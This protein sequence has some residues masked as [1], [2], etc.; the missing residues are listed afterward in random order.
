M[1]QVGKQTLGQF[2]R[3]NCLRQ[4]AFNLYPDNPKFR[5]DRKKLQMP[6]PQSPRPGLRQIQ[7]A[8]EEW[9]EEKLNDLTQTF[10]VEAIIG[11]PYTTHSNHT[12]YRPTPLGQALAGGNPICFMVEAEFPVGPAFQA[13]IGIQRHN[14]QFNLVYAELRPDVIAVLPPASFP[15]FIGPDGTL[16]TLAAHDTR[17]QLRV[18][19]IKM[20]A[21]ASPV[22]F[23]EVAY[24]SMALA[25]WLADMGLDQ[26]YVVVPN[27]AVWPG[28]HDASNLLRV[29]RR[30]DAQGVTPTVNQLWDAMA[31]GP[32]SRSL[33]SVRPSD[34]T[35]SPG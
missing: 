20:T 13:A 19:D 22:Y 28:S 16:H 23:A 18:I 21:E 32:G 7:Q 10:G 1:P 6:Y 14:T 35:L 4:L 33:R 24:Y 15:R 3:T 5:S 2:I 11:S 30:L 31:G 9:Q 17:R 34:S 26:S 25:G 12:R 29:S 27:G 8:G